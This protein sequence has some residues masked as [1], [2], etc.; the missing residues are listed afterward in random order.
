LCRTD[1][2]SRKV[3]MCWVAYDD[4]N[5]VFLASCWRI[6]DCATEARR[7]SGCSQVTIPSS[8]QWICSVSGKRAASPV[9]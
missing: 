4:I 3:L 9:T 1:L 8:C 6:Q 7:N 2:Q 5:S